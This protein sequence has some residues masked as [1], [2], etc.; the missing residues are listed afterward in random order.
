MKWSQTADTVT[1]AVSCATEKELRPELAITPTAVNLRVA[2]RKNDA[3]DPDYVVTAD[4]YAAVNPEGHAWVVSGNGDLLVTA[5]KDVPE[6]WPYPFANREYKRFVGIDWSR[7]DD[8]TN[9]DDNSGGNS[10]SEEEEADEP[11]RDIGALS[12][13]S[14]SDFGGNRDD[15]PNEQNT[16]FQSLVNGLK[17]LGT[18]PKVKLPTI[19]ELQNDMS[20]E[21]IKAL[22]KSFSSEDGCSEVDLEKVA[23]RPL[24]VPAHT[25]DTDEAAAAASDA[26]P[27]ALPDQ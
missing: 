25:D 19:D 8:G 6:M 17:T 11:R 18:D 15:F 1:L 3:S 14:P 10:D 9:S 5:V 13:A 22:L 26:A 20:A 23:V 24:P 16:D 12:E 4:W 2:V 7:W 27:I 21:D